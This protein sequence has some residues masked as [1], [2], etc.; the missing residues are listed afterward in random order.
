MNMPNDNFMKCP[1]CGSA[2]QVKQIGGPTL[3]DNHL[4]LFERFGCKCGTIFNIMYERDPYSGSWDIC[5]VD[6]ETF[7]NMEAFQRYCP[8]VFE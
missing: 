7:I 1:C 4:L 8:K 2:D 3:S 6:F 5:N